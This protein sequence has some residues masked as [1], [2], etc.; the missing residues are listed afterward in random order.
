MAYIDR[1]EFKRK[2][3]DEKSFFPSIVARAIEE[4]PTVN[5]SE[6]TICL[7]KEIKSKNK[8]I[9]YLKNE[10]LKA[11]TDALK[12]LTEKITEEQQC[13]VGRDNKY[14]PYVSVEVIEDFIKEAE[15]KNEKQSI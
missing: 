10:I 13:L 6:F 15:R 5:V 1:E 11:K 7:E 12:E 9:A 14:K 4:M 2:L 3:I 8:L